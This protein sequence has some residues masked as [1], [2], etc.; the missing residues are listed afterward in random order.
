M[1]AVR[2]SPPPFDS[3]R[4]L[5]ALAAYLAN[6]VIPNNPAGFTYDHRTGGTPTFPYEEYLVSL[7]GFEK[8]YSH[9][10][11]PDDVLPWLRRVARVLARTD[12]YIGG[13]PNPLDGR[14]YLDVTV[15]IRGRYRAESIGRL[16]VQQTI[17]HP[18]TQEVIWL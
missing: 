3:N 11:S 8:R 1:L 2:S 7:K 17:F 18:A 10:P 12:T 5:I 6:E 15:P 16:Y 9:L 14:Y 4:D 13:W